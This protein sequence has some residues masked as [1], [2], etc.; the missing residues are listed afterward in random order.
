MEHAHRCA[1]QECVGLLIGQGNEVS[2]FVPLLNVHICPE[3][4]FALDEAE[5]A[6]HLGR[7]VVGLYH[8]HPGQEPRISKLD[9]VAGFEHYWV[10][11]PISQRWAYR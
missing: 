9:Q 8:S 11:D 4:G 5:V 10:V 6:G 3:H 7:G 2:D 1:P